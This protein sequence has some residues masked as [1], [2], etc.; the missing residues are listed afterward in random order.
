MRKIFNTIIY[1]L[2]NLFST[3]QVDSPFIKNKIHEI[4]SII[5]MTDSIDPYRSS[6]IEGGLNFGNSY[7]GVVNRF[8]VPVGITIIKIVSNKHKITFHCNSNG[9]LKIQADREY[10]LINKAYYN[11]EGIKII[12]DDELERLKEMDKIWEMIHLVIPSD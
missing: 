10:Y 1:L 9:I 8:E 3:A 7:T 2:L 11:K 12:S 4:D 5:A 6:K